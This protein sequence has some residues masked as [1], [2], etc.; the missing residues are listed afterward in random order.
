[1]G[2]TLSLF[3]AA[4]GVL[5]G[6]LRLQGDAL[7]FP[8]KEKREHACCHRD[9]VVT[10]TLIKGD[11]EGAS[12]I[13]MFQLSDLVSSAGSRRYTPGIYYDSPKILISLSKQHIEHC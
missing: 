1:M 6:R 3:S 10:D 8:P 7:A 5:K 9:C 4:V 11:S 13:F 12:S 2:S